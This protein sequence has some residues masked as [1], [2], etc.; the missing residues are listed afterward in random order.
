[1]NVTPVRVIPR[2]KSDRHLIQ[3]CDGY[4]KNIWY[5]STRYGDVEVPEGEEWSFEGPDRSWRFQHHSLSSVSHLVDAYDLTQD[6]SYLQKAIE[7]IMGWFNENYPESPSE[8]GWHDHSTAWRLINI[9]RCYARLQ[10]VEEDSVS[11]YKNQLSIIVEIHCLKLAT[12]E[13]YMPKHNHG[14]DQDMALFTGAVLFPDLSDA[15]EWEKLAL[16]RFNKQLDHLFGDEGGYLEH[17]PH[18]VYLILKNLY[19]FLDFMCQI[20]HRDANR[21]SERLE[22]TLKYLVYILRPDGII[23][24]IGDS[25]N[26]M[27]STSLINEWRTQRPDIKKILEKIV[28]QSDDLS[29][30]ANQLTLDAAF[31]DAGMV[32]LRNKWAYEYDTTQILIYSGFHSRVHKHYDD[33][34][35]TL[36]NSGLPLITEGGKYSYEYK[37]KGREYIVSPYAHNSVMVDNKNADTIAKNVEKSGITSYLL[38]KNISYVSGMHAL[39][40]KVNHRRLFVYFK[41]DVLIVIDLLEGIKNHTFDTFFNIHPD[42]HCILEDQVVKGYLDGEQVISI[43]NIY[44]QTNNEISYYRGQYNPLRG[45]VSLNYGELTPNSLIQYR[46]K[47]NNALNVYQISLKESVVNNKLVDCSIDKETINLKWKSFNMQIN[48]TDFYEHLFI[49]EKY[50]RTKKIVKPELIESITHNATYKF[51]GE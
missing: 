13:F 31:L 24:S 42:V 23:P 27:L 40:P 14:L 7:I 44:S 48:L 2:I 39:Y 38:T 6:R 25:E 8:M 12:P 33:L 37:S 34:S 50:Y 9:C 3:K 10:D 26:S 18:Y 36:F 43:Q 21:L 11:S 1:M 46:S 51:I 49:K 45:W 47:G 5:T 17:S 16:I 19:S 29:E 15:T 22:K 41:P 20:N 28:T 4:F 32:A 35:F 30:L